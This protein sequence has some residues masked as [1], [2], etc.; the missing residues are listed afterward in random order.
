M[1]PTRQRDDG[2]PSQPQR[3][4]NFSE[5]NPSRAEQIPNPA[6]PNSKFKILHFVRRIEPFSITYTDPGSIFLFKPIPASKRRGRVGVAFSPGSLSVLGLR[7]R[8]LR[9]LSSR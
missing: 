5:R 7:F 8:F 6:E 9:R 2:N 1:T 3:N 4:P